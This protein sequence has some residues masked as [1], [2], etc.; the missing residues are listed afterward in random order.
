MCVKNIK[1]MQIFN[2]IQITY[3]TNLILTNSENK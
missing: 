2:G 3:S 1:Y